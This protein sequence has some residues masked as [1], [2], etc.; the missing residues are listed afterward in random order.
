MEGGEDIVQQ[1]PGNVEK[2]LFKKRLQSFG[3]KQVTA[4]YVRVEFVSDGDK[5]SW[6]FR[7][8]VEAC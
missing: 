1:V 8:T 5:E 3:T 2:R 6:G 4:D 7:L